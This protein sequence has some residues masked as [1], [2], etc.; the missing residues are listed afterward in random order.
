VQR[1][2]QVVRRGHRITVRPQCVDEHVAV[3]PLVTRQCQ[4]LDER[5]RLPQTPRF[6]VDGLVTTIHTKTTE[7]PYAHARPPDPAYP[8]DR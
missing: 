7:Q 5:A 4:Q 1:L 3:Q 6:G 2:V 8:P